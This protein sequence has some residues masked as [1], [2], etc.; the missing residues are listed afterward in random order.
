VLVSGRCDCG[1]LFVRGSTCISDCSNGINKSEP[2][3]N[4]P[5][6]R[7][8][9]ASAVAADRSSET[10]VH[11]HTMLVAHIRTHKCGAGCGR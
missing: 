5:V 3:L 2:L 6:R 10:F 8:V 11:D 4:T 1:H 7:F 9:A